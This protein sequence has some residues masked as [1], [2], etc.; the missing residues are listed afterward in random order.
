MF[1]FTAFVLSAVTVGSCR[2]LKREAF[3]GTSNIDINFYGLYRYYISGGY[4]ASI[5]LLL[6]AQNSQN[7]VKFELDGSWIT[8]R[9]FGAIVPVLGGIAMLILTL[10]LFYKI[11]KP[12]WL[13]VAS[14]EFVCLFFQGL[15]FMVFNANEC[16]SDTTPGQTR[17]SVKCSIDEGAATAI[18]AMWLFLLAGI[19]MCKTPHP[20]APLF[21]VKM[22]PDE[23]ASATNSPQGNADVD[24]G[25]IGPSAEEQPLSSARESTLQNSSS[26]KVQHHRH[27]R[28]GSRNDTDESFNTSGAVAA[29]EQPGE[30]ASPRANPA[31]APT[32]E[33]FHV[34]EK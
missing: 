2:F 11:D 6:D 17:A 23:E 26:N 29:E 3:V 7:L 20:D 1:A 24:W 8:G 25:D 21:K 18:S 5:D 33:D 16:K 15:T 13:F 34:S 31:P 32:W 10:Q 30:S 12:V 9:A 22:Q 28:K 14:L 4:C 27:H 19:V